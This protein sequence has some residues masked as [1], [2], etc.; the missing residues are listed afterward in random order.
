MSEGFGGASRRIGEE[1][2]AIQAERVGIAQTSVADYQKVV[3]SLEARGMS[4]AEAERTVQA[5][6]QNDIRQGLSTAQSITQ[7]LRQSETTRRGQ[8][9]QREVAEIYAAR[10]TRPTDQESYAQDYLDAARAKGDPRS[11]AEILTEARTTFRELTASYGY[12]GRELTAR[13]ALY[14]NAQDFATAEIDRLT[15]GMGR[16]SPEGRAYAEMTP[17]QQLR[18][19]QNLVDMYQRGAPDVGQRTGGSNSNLPIITTQEQFDALP[20]GAEYIEDG[21]TYRKP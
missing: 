14:D 13:M 15:S 5:Q 17:D 3:D 10:G 8:D 18:Y 9:I 11:D 1:E 16:L 12:Q 20:S 2:A 7:Q 6:V 4:R 19:R 21:V